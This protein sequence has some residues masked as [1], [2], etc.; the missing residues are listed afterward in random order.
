MPASVGYDWSGL[1][2]LPSGYDDEYKSLLAKER[3]GFGLQPHQRRRLDEFRRHY[4]R[5]DEKATIERALEK[6]KAVHLIEEW[7][8]RHAEE[9]QRERL[10]DLAQRIHYSAEIGSKSLHLSMSSGTAEMIK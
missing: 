9:K 7:E 4:E 1:P 6:A 10:R 3:H 2:P 5:E 8:K